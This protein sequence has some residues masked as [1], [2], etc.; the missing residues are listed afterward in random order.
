MQHVSSRT[1]ARLTVRQGLLNRQWTRLLNGALSEDA[2]A[3]Y[4]DIWEATEHIVLTNN[5][6][7]VLWRWTPD[8]TYSAKLEYKMLH[9]R[10]IQFRGHSLIWKTW[11]PLKVKIFLWLTFRQQHWTNDRRVRH[12]MEAREECYICDQAFES[13]DHLLC[14]CPFTFEVWFNI[15]CVLGQPLPAVK[16]SVLGWWRCLRSGWHGKARKGFDSLF[17]L[18]CW[19]IWKERNT[20]CFRDSSSSVHD[21]LHVIKSEAELWM[22]AGARDLGCLLSDD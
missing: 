1:R 18:I 11:A 22:T 12:G 13:I 6:N 8:G 4:L 19:L 17:A 9:S 20:R 7:T 5:R 2:I 16:R 3:E 21:F 10:S 15:Y 14:C